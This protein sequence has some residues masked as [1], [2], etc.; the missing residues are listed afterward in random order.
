MSACNFTNNHIQTTI[1]SDISEKQNIYLHKL[2][3]MVYNPLFIHS[4]L[5]YI[6]LMQT[7]TAFM[8][9]Y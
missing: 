4:T 6:T 8:T 7:I 3:E 2:L 5:I 9:N 1:S